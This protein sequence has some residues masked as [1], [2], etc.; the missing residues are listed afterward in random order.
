MTKGTSSTDEPKSG[1]TG[2]AVG[3]VAALLV[4]MS[5]AVIFARKRKILGKEEKVQ[6]KNEG[7]LKYQF[8][9]TFLYLLNPFFCTYHFVTDNFS[10]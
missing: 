10:I 5:I 8:T 7:K 6:T 1:S 2:P 4:L 3:A 9:Q